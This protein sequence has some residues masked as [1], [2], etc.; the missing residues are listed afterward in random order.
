MFRDGLANQAT[1]QLEFF[2]SVSISEK[3]IVSDAHET[4]GQDVKEKPSE[5]LDGVE[6]HDAL[7]IPV[8]IVL[9]LKGDLGV[10]G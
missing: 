7:L 8:G 2:F 3:A 6:A 10:V 1:N 9:P 5:E 4:F